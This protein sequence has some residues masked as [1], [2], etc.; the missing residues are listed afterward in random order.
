MD[1]TSCIIRPKLADEP[2]LFIACSMIRE[3][4][5]AL[6]ISKFLCKNLKLVNYLS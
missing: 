6:E 5:I 3:R 4:V 2:A 1:E